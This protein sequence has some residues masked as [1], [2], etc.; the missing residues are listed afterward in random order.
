VDGGGEHEEL[1]DAERWKKVEELFDAALEKPDAE[2]RAFLEEACGEDYPLL[3]EVWSLL[4]ADTTGHSLL[5]GVAADH[6]DLVKELSLEGSV[7]GAWSIKE[8]IGTGGMGAVYLAERADGEYE[9][10]AALKIIKRGMNSDEVMRRFNSERQILARLDHPNIARLLDGGVTDDGLPWFTME[11]IEGTPLDDYCDENRLDVSA[12]LN[13]FETVCEAVEYAQHTLIVHRDLKPGNILVTPDGTVKLLDFGIAKLVDDDADGAITRTGVRIMTPAYA[14]PEQ[15]RGDAVTTATDVYALGVLLYELL[16]GRR[17]YRLSNDTPMEY[18]RAILET[19]PERPSTA[20]A[21]VETRIDTDG[22]TTETTAESISETRR[23]RPDALRKQLSG[24][25]DNICLMALRKEAERRY[26]SAQQ[27]LADVRRYRSGRTVAARPDTVAYRVQ[28]F[29]QRNAVGVFSAVAVLAIL[30]GLAGFYSYRVSGERDRARIE[31]GK[32][33]QVSAFLT[34]IFEVSNPDATTAEKVTARELLDRGAARIDRELAGHPEVQAQMMFV[35]GRT[36]FGLGLSEESIAL[37]ERS[38]AIRREVLDE[39]SNELVE[40]LSTLGNALVWAGR[41]ERADSIL[42]EGVARA[43]ALVPKDDELIASISI[44]YAWL[45]NELGDYETAEGL[46]RQAA[47]YSSAMETEP[48]RQH[49]GIALND[50]ALNLH[51]QGKHEESREAFERGLEVQREVYGDVHPE[52]GTILYNYGTLLRDMGELDAAEATLREGLEMD[53]RALGEDHPDI[54]YSMVALAVIL[55]RKGEYANAMPLLED[56][57][58]LRIDKHGG[59]HPSVGFSA[60]HLASLYLAMGEFER[61]DSLWT[62]SMKIHEKTNGRR[63]PVYAIRHDNLGQVAYMQGRY[64][65]AEELHRI[66]IAIKVDTLG[67]DVPNIAISQWHLGNALA[68]Q[69]KYEEAMTIQRI[70]LDRCQRQRGERHHWVAHHYRSMSWIASEMGNTQEGIAYARLAVELLEETYN[71]GD[72]RLSAGYID[73][74]NVL[75]D[76]GEGTE[77]TTWAQ[78]GLDIR[79]NKLPADHYSTGRAYIALGRSLCMS[80]RR[81]AGQDA[82]RE[83]LRILELTFEPAHPRM[84]KAVGDFQFCAA[85]S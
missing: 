20:I 68:R 50:L 81:P 14:A 39:N 7:V 63:H 43:E 10:R 64:A 60:S 56:A 26:V 17:P 2:R 78:K 84:E 12:R 75:C 47:E 3:D 13:L 79:R 62:Y 40:T 65:R 82:F 4:D 41:Y 74:A 24:D 83:G 54:A 34:S 46:L 51:E 48:Q 77:A 70:A 16:T 57:L 45:L 33:T 55:Q 25:L 18:E 58:E 44:N 8:R 35:V 71:E 52:L 36:Y 29:V 11:Y 80:G 66:S 72:L 53:R 27:L 6:I 42:S 23:T 1:M 85:G 31:A 59:S 37:L 69:R 61:A 30:A 22:T 15:V 19:Q 5:D 49:Y 9:Q 28:K 21:R 67:L 73:L 38:L 76:A 32:A